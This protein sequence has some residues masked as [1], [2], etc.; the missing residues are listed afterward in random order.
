MK[1]RE[2]IEE[3]RK[4]KKEKFRKK[5]YLFSVVLTWDYRLKENNLFL[6]HLQSFLVPGFSCSQE[7]DGLI[8]SAPSYADPGLQQGSNN[9]MKATERKQRKNWSAGSCEQQSGFPQ[10]LQAFSTKTEP[11][12]NTYVHTHA[13]PF[14][15]SLPRASVIPPERLGPSACFVPSCHMPLNP[16]PLHAGCSDNACLLVP[17]SAWLPGRSIHTRWQLKRKVEKESKPSLLK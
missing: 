15:A 7:E 8:T 1:T 14:S 12:K 2:E 13:H 4:R 3:E 10:P 9:L 16:V 17:D 6:P 11:R 5:W